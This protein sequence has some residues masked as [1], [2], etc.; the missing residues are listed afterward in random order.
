MTVYEL[1]PA[2]WC[3]MTGSWQANGGCHGTLCATLELAQAQISDFP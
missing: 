1:N 2:Y 3:K